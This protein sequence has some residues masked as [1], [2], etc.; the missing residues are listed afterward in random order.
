V[1]VGQTGVWMRATFREE[2]LHKLDV[3]YLYF[4]NWIDVAKALG[5]GR[6]YVTKVRRDESSPGRKFMAKLDTEYRIAW[7]RVEANIAAN[8]RADEG[9][10][11]LEAWRARRKHHNVGYHG[12]RRAKRKSGKSQRPTEK[13][14]GRKPDDGASSVHA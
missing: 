5:V 4:Q 1:V 14:P 8:R 10:P 7:H 13:K 11:Y 2:L 6:K 9:S 3:M 12:T